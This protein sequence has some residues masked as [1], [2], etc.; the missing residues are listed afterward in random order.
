MSLVISTPNGKG[1]YSNIGSM[2]DVSDVFVSR[3]VAGNY[4]DSTKDAKKLLCNRL[5][6]G[7][8]RISKGFTKWADGTSNRLHSKV[9]LVDSVAY[10]VGS[11][12]AY[13][14]LLQEFGYV[15]Q[16]RASATEFREQYFDPLLQYADLWTDP[17]S[18]VCRI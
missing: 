6:L 15:V 3:L 11:K 9:H 13:P 5:R 12:N 16:D 4:S 17:A 14:A 2:K 10:Y 18:G 7:S 1:G 8:L